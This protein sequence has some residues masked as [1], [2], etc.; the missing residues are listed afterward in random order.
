MI[1]GAQLYTIRDYIQ[2]E[3]DIR[4]S[5]GEVAKMGYTTVQ[6]SA[7]GKIDPHVLRGIC[8]ELGLK[9]V[10]TH[11][12]IDRIINDTD[13]LIEE[14]NILGCD[15]IGL[16]AMPDKYRN[17][18]WIHHFAD[19][20][21]EPV[22]KITAAGKRFM[23]HN[24]NFEFEKV[25]DQKRIIDILLEEFTAEEMG[26]TLDTYW[27]QAAGGSP[28]EWVEI[29]KDRIPCIHLKDM[30]VKGF[31]PA[32]APVMEGNINFKAILDKLEELNC[33][34]YLLVEQD[35]CV[36]SP[37][38]CLKKSYDNLASLGYR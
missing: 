30:T 12:G 29:L 18:W 13:R 7:M 16:G 14:H 15:Y 21:R 27:V 28:L 33:T 35:T 4:F 36:G 5:L 22:Q 6:V 8:D 11:N 34:K 25:D 1:L 3:K 26:I 19:D 9:I 32:M 24:H 38:A 37:F 2:T 23:Y 20:L 10:L 31:S 17:G